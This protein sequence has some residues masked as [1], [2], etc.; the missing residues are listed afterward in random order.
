MPTALMPQRSAG[1]ATTTAPTPPAHSSKSADQP[2]GT[3]QT[4][5]IAE[6]SPRLAASAVDSVVLGPGVKLMAVASASR[7]VNSARGMGRGAKSAVFGKQGERG[8]GRPQTGRN[9]SPL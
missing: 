7:A 5:R 4:K 3:E 2:I 1:T 6:R 8:S 9:A